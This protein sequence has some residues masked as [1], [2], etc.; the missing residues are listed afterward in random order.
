VD[1][2]VVWTIVGSLAGVAAVAVGIAQLRQSRRSATAPSADSSDEQA[3]SPDTLLELS[4]EAVA[5]L[6]ALPGI[7]A[8]SPQK[9]PLETIVKIVGNGFSGGPGA[10]GHPDVTFNGLAAQVLEDWNDTLVSVT[11]PP[12]LPEGSADVRVIT[13]DGLVATLPDAFLLYKKPQPRPV[14]LA[15][16]LRLTPYSKSSAAVPGHPG[17]TRHCPCTVLQHCRLQTATGG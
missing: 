1:A 15:A 17:R 11:L 13:P 14:I 6:A 5:A 10:S 9:G 8:V 7:T 12:D 2:G 16:V 4:P 3:R